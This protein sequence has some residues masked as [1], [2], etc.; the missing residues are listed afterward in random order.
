MKSTLLLPLRLLI[1]LVQLGGNNP[2]AK[3]VKQA[4]LPSFLPFCLLP[5]AFCLLPSASCL[6]PPAF[7][8]LPSASCLLTL[9]LS[10]LLILTGCSPTQ[11]KTETAQVSQLVFSSP[12]N[13]NT[14]N[15]PI[16][17]C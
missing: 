7:C 3:K 8:L 11:F 16:H 6:L 1:T 4:S 13:P 2:P 5:S 9:A 12:S 17:F 15:Y 14:F 10:S